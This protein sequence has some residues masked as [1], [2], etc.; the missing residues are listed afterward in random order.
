MT[1]KRKPDPRKLMEMGVD[2]MEKSVA[3]PRGDGNATRRPLERCRTPSDR[4]CRRYGTDL[5]PGTTT[6]LGTGL[7]RSRA[8]RGAASG[9]RTIG[10][11]DRNG[12]MLY[13]DCIS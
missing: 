13:N 8:D 2:V 5:G 1:V 10:V 3:E 7:L 6:H 9:Q 12:V 11:V 4:P